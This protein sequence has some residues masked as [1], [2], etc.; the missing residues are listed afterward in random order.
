MRTVSPWFEG[1]VS[2]RPSLTPGGWTAAE[3]KLLLD[4]KNVGMSW[5]DISKLF[6]NRSF[7]AA[8]DRYYKHLKP[9]KKSQ[10]HS[11]E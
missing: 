3:D 5:S 10:D 7:K 6:P 4:S 1:S 2:A 8:K 11:A 9:E